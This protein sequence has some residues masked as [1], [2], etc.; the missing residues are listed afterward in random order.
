MK[1]CALF[2]ALIEPSIF[3]DSCLPGNEGWIRG[4]SYV[5]PAY[6]GIQ[7]KK[8]NKELNP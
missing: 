4:Y 6:A 5:M 7:E 8:E 3:L 1:C 2:S